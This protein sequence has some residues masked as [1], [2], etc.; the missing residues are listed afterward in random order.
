MALVRGL[1]ADQPRDIRRHAVAGHGAMIAGKTRPSAHHSGA[2]HR[3]HEKGAR[4]VPCYAG[5]QE[6]V[7]STEKWRWLSW[8]SDAGVVGALEGGNVGPSENL[9]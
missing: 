2:A 5:I 9:A 6:V 7:S 8:F 3:P 1:Q 4:R